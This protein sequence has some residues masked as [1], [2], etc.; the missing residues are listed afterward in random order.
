LNRYRTRLMEAL[1]DCPAERFAWL[2]ESIT[3]ILDS[4]DPV[5]ELTVLSAMARRKMG[6]C[7]TPD[8]SMTLETPAG[9]LS[10]DHWSTADYA[11]VVLILAAI[12]A[13]AGPQAIET[14]F[15]QGDEAERATIVRSLVLF[16]DGVRLKHLIAEAG[17]ANSLELVSA[18]S[19]QN[20]YPK[21]YYSEH[22]FN[23][24]VLKC[25][26]M[27]QPID[28]IPG[29][30]ERGNLELSRMCEDYFDERSAAGREIPCDIWLAMGPYASERAETLMCE[31]LSHDNTAHRCYSGIAIGHRLN[32]RPQLRKFLENR[33]KVEVD[34]GVR[35]VL[36]TALAA[37]AGSG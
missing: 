18:V 22:E 29:L 34:A 15:R 24:L 27:G 17:R 6:T 28:K 31:Y 36:H 35:K 13:D 5:N 11:R 21:V 30:E 10:L 26:F 9:R 1:R 14:L 32:R 2:Q 3:R 7:P 23:Q 33:L 8:V 20:P 4:H 19:L 37:D 12:D 16:D 25:L